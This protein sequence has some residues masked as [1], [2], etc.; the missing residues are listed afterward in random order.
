MCV[1]GCLPFSQLVKHLRGG[2]QRRSLHLRSRHFT[3]ST[4]PSFQLHACH[5]LVNGVGV[6]AGLFSP[7]SPSSPPAREFNRPRGDVTPSGP[8]HRMPAGA[9]A[10]LRL[11]EGWRRPAAG[12]PRCFALPLCVIDR[13]WNARR[14][15]DDQEERTWA[16][17]PQ[18][19]SRGNACS[20]APT[21]TFPSTTARTSPM[22]PASA[23]P[24]QPSS[25]SLATAPGSSSPAIW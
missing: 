16:I 3:G 17:S 19:T 8:R 5:G 23:P 15:D 14:G 11:P 18:R 2:D 22:T 9:V 6:S 25:T 12:D 13:A 10:G 20:C 7:G 4:K 24:S 1:P 21:S